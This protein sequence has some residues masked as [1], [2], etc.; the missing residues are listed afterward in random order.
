MEKDM[1]KDYSKKRRNKYKILNIIGI[2]LILGSIILIRTVP[3]LLLFISII[4]GLILMIPDY[5]IF[6]KDIKNKK[7]DMDLYWYIKFLTLPMIIIIM[8]IGL[9]LYIIRGN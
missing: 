6:Y 1:Y 7:D 5:W 2:L 3:I 4:I 8:V 9:I